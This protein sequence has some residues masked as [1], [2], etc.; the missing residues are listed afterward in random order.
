MG[1][2]DSAISGVAL[3]PRLRC[4]VFG[5]ENGKVRVYNWPEMNTYSRF[6]QF[7]ELF[8]HC[9]VVRRLEFTP[10]FSFLLSSSNDGVLHM[11]HVSLL[12]NGRALPS[13]PSHLLFDSDA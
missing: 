10:D 5:F 3:A 12:R 9:G 11:L 13:L 4:V 7:H 8:L 2:S 6:P 1:S